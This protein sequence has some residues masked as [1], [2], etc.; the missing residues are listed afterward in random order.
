MTRPPEYGGLDL[1]AESPEEAARYYA[2]ILG[3]REPD[4]LAALGVRF[5]AV[6]APG[7]AGWAPVLRVDADVVRRIPAELRE[8][9]PADG[10][11]LGFL[12]GPDGVRV[13]LTAVRRAENA[14][15]YTNV[16]LSTED[17]PGVTAHLAATLRAER[18]AMVD[19]PYDM[20]FVCAARKILFGVFRVR[21]AMPGRPRSFWIGYFEVRDI[22]TAVARAVES[23]SRVVMAPSRSPF[24]EYAVLTD[25]W[26]HLFG[27]SRLLP[28]STLDGVLVVTA[29]GTRRPLAETLELPQPLF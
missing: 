22:G 24:N 19:D 10:I 11:D 5:H 28:R 16:D 7:D 4:T 12:R 8:P 9:E 26:G 2:W 27:L 3:R 20:E 29:D 21:G 6:R 13:A 23:G 17:V 1:F 25:P 18:V 15:R 14:L